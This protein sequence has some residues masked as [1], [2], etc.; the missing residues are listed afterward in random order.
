MNALHLLL[1]IIQGAFTLNSA[2]LTY[3]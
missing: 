2:I 3:F 1:L